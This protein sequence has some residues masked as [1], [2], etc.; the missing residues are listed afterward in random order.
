MVYALSPLLFRQPEDFACL[1]I[2]V[3]IAEHSPDGLARHGDWGQ[4][5]TD[6]F[7]NTYP[8]ED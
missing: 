8:Q 4:G 7:G 5:L 1:Q 6:E 2:N 3:N